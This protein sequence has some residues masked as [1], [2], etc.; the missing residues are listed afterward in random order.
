MG[1]RSKHVDGREQKKSSNKKNYGYFQL[2]NFFFF[3]LNLFFSPIDFYNVVSK[4]DGFQGAS[5]CEFIASS[6]R[7]I[8]MMTSKFKY[9]PIAVDVLSSVVRL[10][11]NWFP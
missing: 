2:W 4:I 1:K 8:E 10:I 7:R 5:N 11:I 3:F 6:K 9:W